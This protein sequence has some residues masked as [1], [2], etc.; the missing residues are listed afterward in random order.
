MVSGRYQA[1]DRASVESS[2]KKVLIPGETKY[3]QEAGKKNE[4]NV[5]GAYKLYLQ[6]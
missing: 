4:V 6:M 1:T 2:I 5:R 3:L